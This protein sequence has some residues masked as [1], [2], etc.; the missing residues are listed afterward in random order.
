ME[1]AEGRDERDGGGRSASRVD[2]CLIRVEVE[3]NSGSHTGQ[4]H[5][6]FNSHKHADELM[7]SFLRHSPSV[8]LSSLSPSPSPLPSFHLLHISPLPSPLNTLICLGL[9]QGCITHIMIKIELVRGTGL[10]YWIIYGGSLCTVNDSGVAD[11]SVA[12]DRLWLV[13]FAV[14]LKC[15]R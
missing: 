3:E 14:T 15:K 12:A 11:S 5:P 2:V 8:F 4:A 6:I 10:T 9:I 13:F 7:R 1:R